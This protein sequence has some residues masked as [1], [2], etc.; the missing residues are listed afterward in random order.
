[1]V[2]V[3]TEHGPQGL[4]PTLTDQVQVQF[5]QC[6]GEPVGVVDL[7]GLDRVTDKGVFA[8]VSACRRL[9]SVDVSCEFWC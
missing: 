9:R 3:G 5:A 7:G 1:M 4:V 8:L 2:H 6:R